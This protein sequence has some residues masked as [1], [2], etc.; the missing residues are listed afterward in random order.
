MTDSNLFKLPSSNPSF[1]QQN[2]YLGFSHF[3]SSPVLLW[4]WLPNNDIANQEKE[5]EAQL[6]FGLLVSWFRCVVLDRFKTKC[7]FI[8]RRVW[9]MLQFFLEKV[10]ES[11]SKWG[12]ELEGFLIECSSILSCSSRFFSGLCSFCPQLT[13]L[14]EKPSALH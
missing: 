8:Y 1:L 10:S 14:M 9:G 6:Y 4:V 7:S 12:L 13:P 11:L 5:N 2:P 3:Y